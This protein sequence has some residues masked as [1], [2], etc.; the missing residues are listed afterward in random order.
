[1]PKIKVVWLIGSNASGKSTQ[2]KL[3]HKHFSTKP[4][5][6]V[7]MEVDGISFSFTDFGKSAHVGEIGNNQCTGTDTLGKK[8]QV[9]LSYFTCVN[10]LPEVEYVILDPI[11]STGKYV[12][13]IREYDVELYLVLLNFNTPEANCRRVQSRRFN[14]TGVMEELTENTKKNIENK[15]KNFL[16]L[17][18]RVCDLCDG[19]MLIN[20]E[21]NEKTIHQHILKLIQ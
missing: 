16:R 4:K 11:M 12:D 21:L 14:K 13:L 7:S 17:F 19:S 9:E 8:Q 10:C 18:N 6:I 5:D 1:M 2:A 3:L 15:R 20:A